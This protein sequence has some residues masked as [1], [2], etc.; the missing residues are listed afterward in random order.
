[1]WGRNDIAFIIAGDMRMRGSLP[2][3]LGRFANLKDYAAAHGVAD[4]FCFLGHV[5]EPE[6]VLSGCH[7]T[8]RPSRE[9]N[10]W[11]RETIES[12]AAGRPVV[13]TGRYD[14]FVEDGVT[15]RL[16]PAYDAESFAAAIL[17]L[18]D[19]DPLRERLAVAASRRIAELCDGPARAS[20]LLTIWQNVVRSAASPD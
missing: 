19:N 11:G 10:P 5:A 12:L 2:G 1:R 6:R 4:A 9:D 17:D 8:A 13:A 15:G 20:D 7:I 16:L 14:R 18:A 3:E